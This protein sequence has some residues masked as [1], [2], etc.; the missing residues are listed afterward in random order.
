[1]LS[2]KLTIISLTLITLFSLALVEE[3][4]A[5]TLCKKVLGAESKKIQL[6]KYIFLNETKN[7]NIYKLSLCC[8]VIYKWSNF[9]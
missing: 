5:T 7:I 4:R 8:S 2:N 6:L 1:M 9:S 3:V